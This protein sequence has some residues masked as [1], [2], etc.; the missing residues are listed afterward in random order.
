M[1]SNKI[2][3]IYGVVC[4]LTYFLFNDFGDKN[5]ILKECNVELSKFKI[6]NNIKNRKD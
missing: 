6:R 2:Y 3:F 5:I 4:G 1:Q